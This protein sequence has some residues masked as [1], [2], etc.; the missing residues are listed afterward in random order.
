MRSPEGTDHWVWGV[1]RE[2]IEPKPVDALLGYY[3]DS[4]GI[5]GDAAEQVSNINPHGILMI[6]L[7]PLIFESGF[8]IYC[9]LLRT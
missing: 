5:M 3:K 4:L 2:I 9:K 1:Y 7:P 8:A 6:F